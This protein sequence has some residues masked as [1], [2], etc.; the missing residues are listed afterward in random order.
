MSA[1]GRG[2]MPAI[3]RDMPNEAFYYITINSYEGIANRIKQ[4]RSGIPDFRKMIAEWYI[5]RQKF[6]IMTF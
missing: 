6:G 2:Y 4:K 3:K 5:T 1:T